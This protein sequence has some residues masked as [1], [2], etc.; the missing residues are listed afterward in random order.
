MSATDSEQRS[1][2]LTRG[3]NARTSAAVGE[4]A[5]LLA[6][7]GIGLHHRLHLP[8]PQPTA[9][10]SAKIIPPGRICRGPRQRA[11]W[12]SA[13]SAIPRASTPSAR[14]GEIKEFTGISAPYEAPLQRAELEL[15]TDQTQRRPSPSPSVLEYLHMQDDDAP[16]MI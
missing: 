1:R 14:A 7:A 5:K 8:L 11:R 3:P 15:R 13:S 9:I 6:D 10:S 4:V 16:A 12:K 2:V